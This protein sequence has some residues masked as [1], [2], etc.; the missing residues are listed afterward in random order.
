MCNRLAA[1]CTFPEMPWPIDS[2]GSCGNSGSMMARIVGIVCTGLLC[3]AVHGESAF[4]VWSRSEPLSPQ[5][6]ADLQA[7]S[8]KTLYWELGVVENKSGSWEWS[9]PP[10]LPEKTSASLRI[11]PVVRLESSVT[12]P[13]APK[14]ADP[15]RGKLLAAFRATDANEWQLDYDA[16]DR[17][18]GDYAD[19]LKSLRP[20]A[21][22]LSSTALA[23]WVRLPAFQKLRGSVAELNPMFYDLIPDT[24]GALRPLLEEDSTKSLLREWTKACDIPWR[25]G[26]PWFSRLTLYDADGKSRGHFRSWSWGDVIFNPGLRVESPEKDGITVLRA[27]DRVIVGRTRV[28]KDERLV[29]R[30]TDLKTVT[31]MEKE[32]ARDVVFFRL[33]DAGGPSG[34]SLCQFKARDRAMESMLTV[35]REGEKL[36]L[37]NEGNADLPPRIRG[38]GPEDRGYALEVEGNGPIFRD[39]MP[40]DFSRLRGHTQPDS[41]QPRNAAVSNATRLTFWFPNLPAGQSLLCRLFQ[42]A[43]AAEG[44][45]LRY[46]ILY[47]P[48]KPSWRP[49][50]LAR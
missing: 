38:D 37:K 11:V 9:L 42:L 26:L 50:D 45:P 39:V 44:A 6:N 30:W 1:C 41:P 19:F 29:L 14:A 31:A 4:W 48:E 12:A 46:R 36:I 22:K 21:P 3:A 17:L 15:L 2:M 7:A 27:K 5:E 23:G 13:F 49:L 35:H 34:G 47:L 40:G 18:V 8:V 10:R 43:P 24:A 28:S 16:P 25:A 20:S 32:A 33:P